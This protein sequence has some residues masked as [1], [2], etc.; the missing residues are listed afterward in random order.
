MRWRSILRAG[1]F[2]ALLLSA[3]T[4]ISCTSH[5][6]YHDYY[7]GGY[8]FT[9]SPQQAYGYGYRSGYDRGVGDQRA[10]YHFDY[11]DGY[12]YRNGISPDR[13]INSAFRDGYARGYRDGYYRYRY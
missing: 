11:D 12:Q 1:L 8:Y 9:G 2:G 4:L 5:Y 10:G 6:G 3:G 13:Y 7:R